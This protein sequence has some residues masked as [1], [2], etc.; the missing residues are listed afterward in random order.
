MATK[1]VD[2][3]GKERGRARSGRRHADCRPRRSLAS[4][5]ED[6]KHGRDRDI[7]RVPQ[8]RAT[9]GCAVVVASNAWILP[10]VGGKPP[11]RPLRP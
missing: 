8:A 2:G 6:K 7:L 3:V 11:P 1:E 9:V 5:E 10:W 4:T